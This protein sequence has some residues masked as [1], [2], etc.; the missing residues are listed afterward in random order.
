MG[1]WTTTPRTWVAGEVVTASQ[2]NANLR[3]FG[4]AFSD[5]WTSYTPTLTAST[6]NPT[7]WTQTGYYMQVGKLVVAKFRLAA[8]ASMT[9]GSGTYRV[10]LPVNAAY[11]AGTEFASGGVEMWDASANTIQIGIASPRNTAYLQITYPGTTTN[12]VGNAAPWTWAANDTIT[13]TLTYEA[14]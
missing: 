14:A 8:G 1:T 9:A 10:A 13:G 2:F 11:T 3:D 4:R 6:T 5:A 7:N 12:T